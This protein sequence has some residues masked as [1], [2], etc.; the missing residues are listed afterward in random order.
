VSSVKKKSKYR[1]RKN[2]QNIH[3][4][5]NSIF[6]SCFMNLNDTTKFQIIIKV[7]FN[8][9]IPKW[10]DIKGYADMAIEK[11]IFSIKIVGKKNSNKI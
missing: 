11:G 3:V 10:L 8:A 7:D 1:S 9:A 4:Q 2:V 5:T 6:K